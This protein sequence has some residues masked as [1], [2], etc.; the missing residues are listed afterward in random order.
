MTTLTDLGLSDS[1]KQE[2]QRRMASHGHPIDPDELE[3]VEEDIKRPWHV[4]LMRFCAFT[5]GYFLLGVGW[6]VKK[7]GEGIYWFGDEM[8]KA[9]RNID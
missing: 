1:A 9:A 4:I 3:I 5:M 2:L 7:F 8:K 6:L